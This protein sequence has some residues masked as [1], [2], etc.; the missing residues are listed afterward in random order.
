MAGSVSVR[1]IRF[2][3]PGSEPGTVV[4][5]FRDP[6]PTTA[7]EATVPSEEIDAD[8]E[9]DEL[10]IAIVD[11][12]ADWQRSLDAIRSP[13]L[14][15]PAILIRGEVRIGWRAGRAV[16]FG[17]SPDALAGLV[18]AAFYEGEL[19]R[20]E[21]TLRQYDGEADRDIPLAFR[22]RFRDRSDWP[23]FRDR[24]ALYTRLR[25]SLVAI[26]PHL[27]RPSRELPQE[28]RR[29]AARCLRATDAAHRA[30]AVG[31]LL[32]T[33]EDLYEGAV[34]RITDYLGYFYGY[35]LEIIIVV[36]LVIEIG[37]MAGEVYMTL[38]V[39]E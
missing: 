2:V 6:R 29:W 4:R 21:R 32:E 12:P 11:N 9:F 19:R 23:R 8:R 14:P 33:R 38:W 5:Q 3:P 22:A 31:E 24:L 28:A 26:A 18:E 37:L 20:I 30:E 13:A 27:T 25:Q 34:D 15:P 16:A 1:R 7:I 17:D 10:A 35:F 39:A 36:L